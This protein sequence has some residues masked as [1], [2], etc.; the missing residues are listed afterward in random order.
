M[1]H[2]PLPSS[3]RYEVLIMCFMFPTFYVEKYLSMIIL[4]RVPT[5]W[6]ALY[7]LGNKV[8]FVYDCVYGFRSFEEGIVEVCEIGNFGTP[9]LLDK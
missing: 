7:Y 2:K 1:V 5:V 6:G 4:H 9:S 8:D 3:V